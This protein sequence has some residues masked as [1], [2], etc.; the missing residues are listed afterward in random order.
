[1]V[2][3]NPDTLVG[4]KGLSIYD[5]M[6]K[7]PVVAS[8]LHIKKSFVWARGWGIVP[9]ANASDEAPPEICDFCTDALD[10]LP[11]SITSGIEKVC[12]ALAKGYSVVNIVWDTVQTGK[13]AGKWVPVFLVD[14]DPINYDFKVDVYGHVVRVHSNVEE[15]DFSPDRF[16]LYSYRPA[17][18]NPYGE[19]DLRQ[20]YRAWWCKDQLMRFWSL[21]LERFG[22]PV[23][24]G[25]YKRGAPVASQAALLATINKLRS[26][27]GFVLPDDQT[28][29][30]L[31]TIRQG[32]TGFQR[33]V[34][35]HDSQIA[36]A[37]LNQTM[38]TDSGGGVGSF[39]LAKVHLDVL[40]M[41]LLGLKRDVEESVV[42]DQLLRPMVR[43]NFGVDAPVPSFSL[44]QLD[45]KEFE[46]ASR[47][48]KN[49]VECGVIDAGDPG[50]LPF[51]G[52]DKLK[53]GPGLPVS[54]VSRVGSRIDDP[55]GNGGSVGVA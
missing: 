17:Y 7:D 33:A 6:Q 48:V 55:N 52:L 34:E 31:E 12:D 3:Y 10:N 11:G 46:P 41:S 38:V 5:D 24:R 1:M 13:W 37:I 51:L 28:V 32:D 53:S 36:R 22:A 27:S 14:K 44:G 15:K 18:G 20:A 39:A 43:F 26:Q 19:S 16:I 35:Y 8:S 30:F 47:A 42:R 2:Q 50:L 4:R 23:T 29:E 25:T 40:R 45:E 49:L 54:P 21:Y 9:S